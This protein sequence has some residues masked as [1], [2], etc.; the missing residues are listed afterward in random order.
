M[1]SAHYL[2]SGHSSEIHLWP[3]T[4]WLHQAI[5]LRLPPNSAHPTR[6]GQGP[7]GSPPGMDRWP[8]TEVREEQGRTG[9]GGGPSSSSHERSLAAAP[10][11]CRQQP[12][13]SRC[14]H[15]KKRH[16][17]V[18]STSRAVSL[19]SCPA[20]EGCVLPH[21]MWTA[22]VHLPYTRALPTVT[23]ARSHTQSAT[24]VPLLMYA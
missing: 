24:S 5:W 3:P 4:S 6:R 21:Q 20:A 12:E 14:Q 10:H 19:L 7:W 17:T 1:S 2:L 11:P 15:L 23:H 22:A 9:A 16:S 8:P 13:A 18:L